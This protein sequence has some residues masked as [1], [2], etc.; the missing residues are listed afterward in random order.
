MQYMRQH[1][2]DLEHASG[3]HGHNLTRAEF[4]ETIAE[5]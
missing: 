3:M 5:K 2:T 1:N 4:R